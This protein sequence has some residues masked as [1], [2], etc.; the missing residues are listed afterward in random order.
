MR[1]GQTHVLKTAKGKLAV[2]LALILF[3]AAAVL[4]AP[5]TPDKLLCGVIAAAGLA[6]ACAGVRQDRAEKRG[7]R[8][9]D[10]EAKG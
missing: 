5:T 3:G 2:G 1:F 6:F 7:L 9:S 10:K 4:A 8:N